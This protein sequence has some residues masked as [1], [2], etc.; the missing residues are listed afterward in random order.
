M[1]VT[2]LGYKTH[3]DSHSCLGIMGCIALG[4]GQ[5]VQAKEGRGSPG[6]PAAA[7]ARTVGGAMAEWETTTKQLLQ[8]LVMTTSWPLMK[9]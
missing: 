7:A 8:L 1:Q 6:S 5:E 4:S 2:P 3:R 9:N